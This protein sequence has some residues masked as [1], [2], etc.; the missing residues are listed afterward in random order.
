MTADPRML[1]AS[2][3]SKGFLRPQGDPVGQVRLR[4]K[5]KRGSK[6]YIILGFRVPTTSMG[7]RG[8]GK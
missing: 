5:G 3:G 1:K 7:V 2:E 6:G 4:G 8:E